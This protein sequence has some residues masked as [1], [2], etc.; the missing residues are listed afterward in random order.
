MA[1]TTKNKGQIMK[2]GL[3][4]RQTMVIISCVLGIM[5]LEGCAGKPKPDGGANIAADQKSEAEKLKEMEKASL[6]EDSFGC[7]R[8]VIL[9]DLS[10]QVVVADYNNP[11]AT[12]N[13]VA[14]IE[15][16]RV[17]HSNCVVKLKNRHASLE[18]IVR[19][20]ATKGPDFPEKENSISATYFIIARMPSGEV[21]GKTE[22]EIIL[23][24]DSENDTYVGKIDLI[25]LSHVEVNTDEEFDQLKFFVGLQFSPESWAFHQKFGAQI[26]GSHL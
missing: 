6:E 24:F 7:P 15:L 17:A 20:S 12:K 2:Q 4:H 25:E 11:F 26:F 5:M 10:R 1:R 3:I 14:R 22:K 16:E 19:I 21:V 9:R 18:G 8:P 13:V 23:K